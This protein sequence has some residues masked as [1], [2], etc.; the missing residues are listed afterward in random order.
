MPALINV[1]LIEID[2]R[3]CPGLDGCAG[4]ERRTLSEGLEA[5][6]S[7]R[8]ARTPVMAGESGAEKSSIQRRASVDITPLKVVNNQDNSFGVRSAGQTARVER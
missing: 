2:E 6:S 8:Y 1:K 5:I 3:S 7:E 4:A